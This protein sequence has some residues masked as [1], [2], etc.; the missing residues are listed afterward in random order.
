MTRRVIVN[1]DDFGISAGVNRGIAAAHRFGVVTSASLMVRQPAV[2]DAV[3]EM[4]ADWREAECRERVRRAA[5]PQRDH[6]I[7][8][9]WVASIAFR[10]LDGALRLRANGAKKRKPGTSIRPG[11]AKVNRA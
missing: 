7:C 8:G 11:E 9:G 3:R 6:A 2:V 1:A 10:A 5:G 4:L